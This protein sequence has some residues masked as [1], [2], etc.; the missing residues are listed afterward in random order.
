MNSLSIYGFEYITKL[1]GWI[2]TFVCYNYFSG[3]LAEQL[4]SGLQNRVDG[5]DSRTCL[6]VVVQFK[7][8]GGQR[9][10]PQRQ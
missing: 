1:E 5:C 3:A 4:R 8:L 2:N 9:Q 6:H 10:G 7:T